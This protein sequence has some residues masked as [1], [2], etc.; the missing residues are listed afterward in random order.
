MPELNLWNHTIRFIREGNGSWIFYNGKQVFVNE[1]GARII[2]LASKGFLD[3]EIAKQIMLE[4]HVDEDKVKADITFLKNKLFSSVSDKMGDNKSDVDLSEDSI[5]V[6]VIGAGPAGIIAA[7]TAAN[8]IQTSG[9][10]KKVILL[11]P[12]PGGLLTAVPSITMSLLP[13]MAFRSD[14]LLDRLWQV[15]NDTGVTLIREEVVEIIKS[16][17]SFTI[18]STYNSFKTD[19]LIFAIG[20]TDKFYRSVIGMPNVFDSLMLR[21]PKA[22]ERFKDSRVTVYGAWP[23]LKPLIEYLK[24]FITELNI[25]ILPDYTGQPPSEAIIGEVVDWEVKGG[26]LSQVTILTEK[27]YCKI[28]VYNYSI[29]DI[30]YFR[31]RLPKIV[32]ELNIYKQG[33]LIIGVWGECQVPGVFGCGDCCVGT[34]G[35]N[36][37]ITFGQRAGL[38]AARYVVGQ[39]LKAELCILP[40]QQRDHFIF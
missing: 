13:G 38:M 39:N 33:F 11:D 27:V 23:G 37:A 8:Y 7:G 32:G 12:A 26:F 30:S 10:A 9:S 3:E 20:M 21:S 28:P 34:F 24:R 25:V 19:A 40:F 16:K 14:V 18:V 36:S 5:G 22:F 17:D 2:E 35:V 15:I 6:V 31:P 29:F 1:V 4:F